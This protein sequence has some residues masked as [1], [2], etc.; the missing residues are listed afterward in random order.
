MNSEVKLFFAF[1]VFLLLSAESSLAIKPTTVALVNTYPNDYLNLGYPSAR[2]SF[3]DGSKF[4]VFFSN[5]T[6]T[7][8]SGKSLYSYS[9]DGISWSQPAILRDDSTT[10]YY[11]S[12]WFKN[13][14]TNKTVYMSMSQFT[15]AADLRFRR[16][17]ITGATIEWEPEVSISVTNYVRGTFV[18]LNS[19][20]YPWIGFCM[21]NDSKYRPWVVSVNNTAG[22][23]QTANIAIYN[24]IWCGQGVILT[25]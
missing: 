14:T 20:D 13:F 2:A 5:Y 10:H 11:M 7:G 12:V 3:Y 23:I 25:Q 6:G 17:N 15:T 9:V 24:E 8:W 19:S 22:D 4:W 1:L 16:R 21:Y 18:T